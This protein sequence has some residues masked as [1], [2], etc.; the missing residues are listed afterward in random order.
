MTLD[1]GLV[2]KHDIATSGG[3]KKKEK[4]L[5]REVGGLTYGEKFF[6]GN[7]VIL[8]HPLPPVGCIRFQTE[9]TMF[10]RSNPA[11]TRSN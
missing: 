4:P 9:M 6:S 11:A 8:I 2:A 3:Q 1:V 5:G 10:R 7:F